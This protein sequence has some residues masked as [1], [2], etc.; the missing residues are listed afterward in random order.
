MALLLAAVL[1]LMTL[2]VLA[3]GCLSLSHIHQ[4]PVGMRIPVAV[5]VFALGH[6]AQP[7]QRLLQHGSQLADP[8]TDLGLANA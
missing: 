7:T 3:P 6:Q 4:K 5:A 1:F 2:V 8:L